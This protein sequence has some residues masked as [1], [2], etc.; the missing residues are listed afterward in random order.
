MNKDEFSSLQYGMFVHFGIYSMI[1]RGEWAM[2]RE[3]IA[4]EEM[5]KIAAD[6]RPQHFDADELCRLAV[7]GGMRYIVFTTMHH[8]GF[9]MY[10]T[11]LSPFNSMRLLGRDFAN[12]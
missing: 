5:E 8:D 7:D 12:A 1:G 4:P 3:R 9:R 2:N 6:F 11:A 10:D